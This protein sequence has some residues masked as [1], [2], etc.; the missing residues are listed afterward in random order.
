V[1][2]GQRVSQGA[3][4]GAVGAT[5]LATGP[6]L[7]YRMCRDGR[8]VDP[9]RLRSAPAAPVPAVERAAFDDAVRRWSALLE[10]GSPV[11]TAALGQ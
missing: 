1:R 5:G 3:R 4:I 8:F 6:H 9:L 11:R 7:D 10:E 2:R